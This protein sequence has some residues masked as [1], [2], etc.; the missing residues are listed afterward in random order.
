MEILTTLYAHDPLRYFIWDLAHLLGIADTIITLLHLA[1]YVVWE[2]MS[3]S[4]K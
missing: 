1:G 4:P 2:D 3:V